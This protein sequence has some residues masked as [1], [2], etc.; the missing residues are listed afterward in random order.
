M[1]TIIKRTRNFTKRYSNKWT[2][3][4]A[5]ILLLFAAFAVAKV[6]LNS[7][8]ATE[9]NTDTLR[10]VVVAPASQAASFFSVLETTG[11]V[12]SQTQGDLRAQ[13]AGII[14][15]VN[16][17]VGQSV[18]AGS[19]VATI[20]NASE[21]ASV[22]QAQAGVAQAQAGLNKIV[23]GTREEQLAVL[24][25]NTQSARTSLSEAHV[26]VKNTLRSAYTTTDTAIVGGVDVMFDDADSANPKVE[27]VSVNDTARIR[28]E[29]A[30]LSVQTI[31]ERHANISLRSIPNQTEAI[32]LELNRVESEMLAFKELLDNLV[33]ALDGGIANASVSEATLA[34][35]KTTATS[36][37]A[38]VLSQLS[39]ISSAR[40]SLNAAETALTVALEN[41]E[42][43]VVGSQ[44]EDIDLAQAQVDSARASLAQAVAG[45]EETR[46]RAPVSGT[47]TV[48]TLELG[49]FVTAFQ[50]VG[51]IA[52]NGTLE[53]QT[54]ISPTV[55]ERLRVGGGALVAERYN[56][57]ITS[58]AP[59]VDPSRRQI[60]VRVAL[61]DE[62]PLSHGTR[63]KVEF[64]E[65][66]EVAAEVL[67]EIRIPVSA[68][69]LIGD[70][71]FVFTVEDGKLVAHPVE[72]GA[73]VQSTVEVK[74]GI[75]AATRIVVD[76]RG[77][78]EGDSVVIAEAL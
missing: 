4:A 14:T 52:N 36:A 42:Q 44:Q 31:V 12:K 75:D 49:D 74:G 7:N 8:D 58:I 28:A 22:A 21:R 64:L 39:S 41:Q 56:G 71:A 61:I 29:N 10:S 25:A 11:E 78:N 1:S 67:T 30:R 32:L 55:V 26:S 5:A 46:I 35:Y 62:V 2:I 43:G 6:A 48:L 40:A 51:V 54:F 13:R 27:F 23:G 70:A 73:V 77:L 66:T 3:L 50:D 37:R 72:L 17:Q 9:A 69:K 65:T 45:L 24:R 68:L 34:T 53:V 57:V 63:T 33:N 60:E 20:E 38:S 15:A 16:V 59:G 18:L 76:A 19:I 47:V